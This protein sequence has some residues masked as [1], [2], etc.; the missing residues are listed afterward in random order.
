MLIALRAK[1]ERVVLNALVRQLPDGFAA[2]IL[3]FRWFI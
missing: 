1:V 2:N 3:H